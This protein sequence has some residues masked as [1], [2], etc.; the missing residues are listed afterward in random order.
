MRQININWAPWYKKNIYLFLTGAVSQTV[1]NSWKM[2]GKS[3]LMFY[4]GLHHKITEMRPLNTFALTYI[5]KHFTITF[6]KKENIF[7]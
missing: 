2:S 3:A 4:V 1:D 5:G 6:V 7:F